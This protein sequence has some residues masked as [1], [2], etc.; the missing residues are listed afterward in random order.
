VTHDPAIGSRA[1]RHLTLR[2]G[3]IVSDA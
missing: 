1:S 3:K 2:D